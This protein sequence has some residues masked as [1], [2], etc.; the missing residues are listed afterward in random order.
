LNE[1]YEILRLRAKLATEL[2]NYD[3]AVRL[4]KLAYER[5]PELAQARQNFVLSLD[6]SGDHET[7]F[8]EAKKLLSTGVRS[9]FLVALLIR[10]SPAAADLSAHWKEIEPNLESEED[11]NLALVDRYIAWGMIDDATTA[12]KRAISISPQSAHA[13]FVSGM[14]AHNAA[15]NGPWRERFIRLEEAIGYYTKA[16]ESA[17][18]DKLIGLLPEV[19]SNRGRARSALNQRDKAASDLRD[20]VRVAVNP[21][22]YAE[23]AVRFFLNIDDFPA[24]HELARRLDRRTEEGLY[25][26]AVSEYRD[27]SDAQKKI[28]LAMM[29]QVANKTGRF[30]VDAR[31]ICVQWALD[32]PDLNLARRCVP[33][34]F[35][36]RHPL[37]GN[38]LR[39]WIALKSADKAKAYELALAALN[40]SSRGVGNQE[41]FNLAGLLVSI[42]EDE[43][44]LPL[45]EQIIARGVLDES[46]RRLLATAQRLERH[47]VLLRVLTDLGET[48]QH[49]EAT[50]RL[51][52][53]VLSNYDRERALALAKEYLT[54]DP[55]FSIFRNYLAA[56]LGR[57]DDISFDAESTT[58]LASIRPDDAE[59]VVTPYIELGRYRDALEFLYR[60]LRLN[61]SNERAH[62]QY[63]Y[64]IIH[65]G[66]KAQVPIDPKEFDGQSAAQLENLTTKTVRWVVA[67]DDQPNPAQNEH[68]SSSP[69]VQALLGKRIGDEVDLQGGAIQSQ[70]ERIVCLQSK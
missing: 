44:A 26:S 34:G 39:G 57:H 3:E 66:E 9:S 45:F 15:L 67:E 61:S 11:V 2:Q 16:L 56:T 50:R 28:A 22:L 68:A 42:G 5:R 8:R 35:V 13:N 49:D 43:K 32:V 58:I 54:F 17:E 47:D 64:F 65:Y 59:L 27:D 18:R 40:S 69:V 33:N 41:I 70:P 24:A 4:F 20:A 12:A 37:S 46:C 1:Q 52:V 36:K 29:R 7:A 62:G 21:N 51:E 19:Y 53:Q 60:Q 55:Y 38:T 6:F 48:G 25:L 63:I 14:A 30:E 31:S 10:N 23:S